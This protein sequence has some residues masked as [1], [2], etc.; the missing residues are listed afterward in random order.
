MQP[1]RRQSVKEKLDRRRSLQDE[2]K[3]ADSQVPEAAPHED[4]SDGEFWCGNEDVEGEE[5]EA[6]SCE[7]E[8]ALQLQPKILGC[9]AAVLAAS[10]SSSCGCCFLLQESSFMDEDEL[11]AEDEDGQRES[12][13]KILDW[14]CQRQL[15]RVLRRL[16]RLPKA[17]PFKEPLPWKE[18]GLEDYPE[19]VSDPI[20]LRT[21]AERLQD[22]SYKDEEGFVNPDFFW[23]DI[24]L[25]WDNCKMYYEDDHE[26]E[27]V[28]MAEEMKVE[29]EKLEDEFWHDLEKLGRLPRAASWACL[30]EGHRQLRMFEASLDRVKGQALS[31]VAAVADVAKG[32]M[33]DAATLAVEESKKLAKRT[34]EWWNK[35]RGKHMEEEHKE[36]QV[37]QLEVKP[38]IRDHFVEMLKMRFGVN[39]WEDIMGIEEEVLVGMKD[40]WPIL[41][42]TDGND[43][44]ARDDGFSKKIAVERLLPTKYLGYV[45]GA[46][47]GGKRVESLASSRSSLRSSRNGPGGSR[48]NSFESS[49]AGSERSESRQQTPRSHRSEESHRSSAFSHG[50]ETSKLM[51]RVVRASVLEAG[52]TEVPGVETSSESDSDKLDISMPS[53]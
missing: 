31:K 8:P 45:H 7:L 39:G 9:W 41:E 17:G 37:L 40:N 52:A 13:D 14:W 25:C 34:Q 15:L 51:T 49:R 11:E 5:S 44:P 43:F 48:R 26:I 28:R 10:H 12:Q 46:S 30:K 23:Q 33:K 29:S 35:L 21:I 20:D 50:S 3:A 22:G 53:A 18:L 24:T 1:P 6:S 32:A 16:V 42:D 27:A 2:L 36:I 38:R 19:V 47:R 4:D